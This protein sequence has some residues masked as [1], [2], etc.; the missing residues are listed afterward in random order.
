M[1]PGA[2]VRAVGVNVSSVVTSQVSPLHWICI[3]VFEHDHPVLGS[4]SAPAAH[5]AAHQ[6]SDISEIKRIKISKFNHLYQG[7]PSTAD[8]APL[9]R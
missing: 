6:T 9:I 4:V 8:A 3:W 7:F 1:Y 5:A 2:T